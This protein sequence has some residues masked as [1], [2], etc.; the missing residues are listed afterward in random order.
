MVDETKP[1]AMPLGQPIKGIPVNVAQDPNVPVSEQVT[2]EAPVLSLVEPSETPAPVPKTEAEQALD[3][4]IEEERASVL[5]SIG[6]G[7][8]GLGIDLYRSARSALIYERDPNFN[9]SPGS[10]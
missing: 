3:L 5:A 9:P 8:G 2:G 1:V 6:A 7:M 10:C 4:K